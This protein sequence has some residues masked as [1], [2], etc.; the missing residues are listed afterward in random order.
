MKKIFVM[1]VMAAATLTANAQWWAGGSFALDFSSNAND[2][3]T[4]FEIAPEVGY[5]LSDKWSV[6][7]ALGFGTSNNSAVNAWDGT[8]QAGT[9]ATDESTMTG[10][11]TGESLNYFK[12][13]PYVRY[14]FVKWDK[15][16]IFA[17]GG[18]GFK[19]YN[20][21]R[22]NS[23]NV[24]IAPGIAFTPTQKLSLVARIGGIGYQKDSEKHGDGSKFFIGFANNISFGAYYNF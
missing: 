8:A 12:I 3:M 17:D 2:N 7:V 18:V 14:S 1:A 9:S 20:Q 19:V 15:V 4:T 11:K 5:N 16:S 21:D 10:M 6:A 13:A 23:I 24:G 22:G